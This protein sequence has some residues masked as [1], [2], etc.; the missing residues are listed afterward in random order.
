M[1]DD[2]VK[3]TDGA[4]A[5]APAPDRVDVPAG[6]WMQCPACEAIV[7]QKALEEALHVCPECG[8]HHRIPARTRIEQ[9]VVG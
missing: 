8:Y 9:L 2:L 5:S 1:A 4:G 3:V 7:Y 6:L